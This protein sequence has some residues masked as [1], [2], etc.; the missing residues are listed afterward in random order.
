VNAS[1]FYKP[2]EVFGFDIGHSTIKVVQL[3]RS[4][5][6]TP[7]VV[8][9]GY[10]TFDE[11]AIEEGIVKNPKVLAESAYA[12]LTQL[13]VGTV[14]TNRVALS[15]PASR[16]FTRV[17]TLPPL[18]GLSLET[19]VRVEAEQYIPI[20]LDQLY[21]DYEVTKELLPK[22]KGDESTIEVVMVAAPQAVVDSYLM[23]LDVLNLEAAL[24]ESS[25][26]ANAR[27]SGRVHQ[28]S[29]PLLLIDFGSRSSDI[30]IFD[31]AFRVAGTIDGGG[32]SI[33][34]A[35]A[36]SFNVTSRQAY[37][38]KTRNGLKPGPHQLAIQK[39]I[40]PLLDTV[41]RETQ[42]ILRFYKDRE[43]KR[44]DI[45]AI[46]ISGGGANL[47]G[48][49]EYLSEKTKLQ[50]VVD[51]PWESISFGNL[52]QPHALESTIYTTA[53]GL[54]YASVEKPL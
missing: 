47:P 16:C 24:V 1:L 29:K 20:P 40:S 8:G 28:A 21:I 49:A 35:I 22:D 4:R 14:T 18:T 45:E 2:K 23:L 27:T 38:L 9:Y 5:S 37:I 53:V 48:L 31:G 7:T 30:N 52:Q 11:H 33:T 3:S 51:N 46:V 10:N 54:A 44:A 50:V 41:M 34:D 13:L 6:G 32:D 25:L 36:R 17:L 42:K 15:I 43:N 39:A 12:L 26:M 19:A